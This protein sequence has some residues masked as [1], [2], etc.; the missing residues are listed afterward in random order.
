MIQ[1]MAIVADGGAEELAILLQETVEE[2][3]QQREV[4]QQL[5]VL[6]EQNTKQLAESASRNSDVQQEA[7]K[8]RR[9][10]T[11]VA[12][13]LETRVRYFLKA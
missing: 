5:K 2:L 1:E 12:V 13:S 11:R 4:N 9:G 6:I 8:R 3:K 10:S 7:S